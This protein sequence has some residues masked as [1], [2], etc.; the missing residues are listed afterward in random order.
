MGRIAGW[1][2]ARIRLDRPDGNP[3]RRRY[4]RLESGLV[5]ALVLAFMLFLWPAM[6]VGGSVYRDGLADER[7]G[8]GARQ[9]VTAVLTEDAPE[10]MNAAGAAFMVRAQ[11]R[12]TMPDGTAREGKVQVRPLT[13]AGT[14][15]QIWVDADGRPTTPPNKRAETITKAVFAATGVQLAATLGLVLIYVIGRRALDRRRY[16]EWDIAW[17][18]ADAKWRRRQV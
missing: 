15:V 16:R 13:R 1:I 14:R 17:A 2:G 11:A 12:W 4:D 8:P 10:Q 18:L 5:L 3:L 9:L 6:L 7:V